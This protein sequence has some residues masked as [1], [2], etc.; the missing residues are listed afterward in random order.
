MDL[1]S[2]IGLVLGIGCILFGIFED[3]GAFLH[4]PSLVIVLGGGIS[5]TMISYRLDE[6]TKVVITSYSIHYTKLYEVLLFL[7]S[8]TYLQEA[9]LF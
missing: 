3:I 8:E 2:I 7:P 6:I 9:V 1:A 5:S 4:I